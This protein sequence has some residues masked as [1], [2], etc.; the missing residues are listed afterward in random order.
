MLDVNFFN[1]E[2]KILRIKNLKT[3]ILSPLL[4]VHR[5]VQYKINIDFIDWKNVLRLLN[6]LIK[7]PKSLR[8]I[9]MLPFQI[10]F[11]YLLCF[12]DII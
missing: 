12:A 6:E 10:Y 4:S 5:L 8:T 7:K 11:P 3:E 1:Q 2:Q 9:S